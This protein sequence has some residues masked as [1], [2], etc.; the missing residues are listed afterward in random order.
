M[1]IGVLGT[2][3]VGQ[4][5]GKAF[6]E[7]GHEVKLGSRAAGNE[8][9]VAWAEV[10]NAGHDGKASHGT[11][12]DAVKFGELIVIAILWE[13]VKPALDSAGADNFAG[14]IVIDATNPLKYEHGKPP[15]LDIGLTD[16][17]GESIQRWLPNA[18]VVK[19]FNTV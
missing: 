2:G 5:L 9:A 8:K 10:V 18:R 17:A 15:A 3:E 14:K 4:T 13:G 7:L 6:V 19:A 11:Y 1:K 12:G 16:S